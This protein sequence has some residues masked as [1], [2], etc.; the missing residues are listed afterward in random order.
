[1]SANTEQWSESV[2]LYAAPV[3]KEAVGNVVTITPAM[4]HLTQVARPYE[5]IE[6]GQVVVFYVRN[7]GGSS[8][9]SG[10]ITIVDINSDIQWSMPKTMFRNSRAI[11]I[12]F[13]VRK[14][15]QPV[16]DSSED[17]YLIKH[18]SK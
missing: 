7:Y 12:F 18:E 6:V 17:Q 15:G 9:S 2:L 14:D 10:D 3:I 4:T 13:K 1:M 5:G 16:G 11:D 8:G